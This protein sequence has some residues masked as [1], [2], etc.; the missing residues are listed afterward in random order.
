MTDSTAHAAHSHHGAG[1]I[2]DPA[3]SSTPAAADAC[4]PRCLIRSISSSFPEAVWC[5]TLEG[6]TGGTV[7]A[8]GPSLLPPPMASPAFP[9]LPD[10]DRLEDHSDDHEGEGCVLLVHLTTSSLLLLCKELYTQREGV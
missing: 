6:G 5:A 4:T 10:P 3:A 1:R 2:V 7:I 9:V 8:P